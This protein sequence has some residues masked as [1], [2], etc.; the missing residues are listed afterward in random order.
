[1]NVSDI[2]TRVKRSFGDESGVQVMDEDILRWINDGQLHVVKNNEGLLEKVA[3][4]D[5]VAG[6]Q[7]YTLP[8]D[9]LIL[10]GITFK[11]GADP[12][13]FKLKGFHLNDFNEFIDGWDGDAFSQGIPQVYCLYAGMMK[14]FPEPEASWTAAIKIY[15][16]RKPTDVSSPTDT[17]DLP[18]IYHEALVKYCLQQA[19][20]MDEDW[21]AAGAK[22]QDLA[23]DLNLLRGREDWKQEEKYSM[24]SIAVED[25]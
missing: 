11:S 25:L 9:L 24:I 20:E 8:E 13:Y 18:A 15:Y 21:Q 23:T 16:T 19:Y 4:T 22:S 5:A 12:A 2:M 14:F 17:P 7:D 3:T 10:K 1:M 6:Q